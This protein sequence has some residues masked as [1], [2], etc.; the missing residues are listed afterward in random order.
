M[1]VVF[2]HHKLEFSLLKHGL[3]FGNF[4]V[5]LVKLFLHNSGAVVPS[6]E[7]GS[8]VIFGRDQGLVVERLRLFL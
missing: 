1:E 8:H 4:S 3:Q 6:M 2:L 7:S 5:L